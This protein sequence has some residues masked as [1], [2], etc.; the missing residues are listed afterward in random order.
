LL[1]EGWEARE[2]DLCHGG[3]ADPRGSVHHHE[4]GHRFP[5]LGFGS[6]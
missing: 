5:P 1:G 2:D 4:L 3:L 6:P